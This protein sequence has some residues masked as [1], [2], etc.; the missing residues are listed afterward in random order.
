MASDY[1]TQESEHHKTKNRDKTPEKE[2]GPWTSDR[3]GAGGPGS[4]PGHSAFRGMRPNK[5]IVEDSHDDTKL[6]ENSP[7]LQHEMPEKMVSRMVSADSGVYRRDLTDYDGK[8]NF[9]ESMS[10]KGSE[11]IIKPITVKVDQQK[12]N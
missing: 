10:A 1:N 7:T 2:N 3:S 4:G 6:D 11:Q 9:K 12:K 5:L 8:S